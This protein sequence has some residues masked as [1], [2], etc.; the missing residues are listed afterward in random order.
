MPCPQY[1]C[2]GGTAAPD[3]EEPLWEV[4]DERDEKLGGAL[5]FSL[6]LG[7]RVTMAARPLAPTP[8]YR[9]GLHRL[10]LGATLSSILPL[11]FFRRFTDLHAPDAGIKAD[12]LRH[13]AAWLALSVC[14]CMHGHPRVIALFIAKAQTL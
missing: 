14:A 9:Q 13:R 10:A 8:A 1:V 7:V 4:R 12:N 6:G 2:G 11:S 3:C 5:L